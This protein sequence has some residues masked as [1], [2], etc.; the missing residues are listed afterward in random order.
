M[1]Y[2]IVKYSNFKKRNIFDTYEPKLKLGLTKENSVPLFVRGCNRL[3]ALGGMIGFF[4]SSI[5]VG[6]LGFFGIKRRVRRFGFNR[7]FLR[8]R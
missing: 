7:K 4:A 3:L 6:I 5:L 1:K 8:L 2:K